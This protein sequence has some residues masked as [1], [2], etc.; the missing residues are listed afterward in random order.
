MSSIVWSSGWN[1]PG[2]LP[3]VEPLNF[4]TDE[5]DAWEQARDALA[6][7]LEEARDDFQEDDPAVAALYV[8]TLEEL[9]RAEPDS[10]ITLRCGNCVWWVQEV[11]LPESE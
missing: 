10:N 8:S 2:Y 11:V 7:A 9:M 6:C 3:D 5:Q 4:E 1:I